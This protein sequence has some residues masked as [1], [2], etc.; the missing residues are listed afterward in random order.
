MPITFAA[1]IAKSEKSLGICESDSDC[2]FDVA[3]DKMSDVRRIN[4]RIDRRSRYHS[5]V[6]LIHLFNILPDVASD[7]ID[8]QRN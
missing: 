2:R 3:R 7:I 1:A 5:D 6:I 8:V 4:R